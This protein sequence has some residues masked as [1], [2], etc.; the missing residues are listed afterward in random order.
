M[1]ITWQK[2]PILGTTATSIQADINSALTKCSAFQVPTDSAVIPN[3]DTEALPI[4]VC[5]RLVPY[6]GA[7]GM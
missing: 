3:Q 5:A 6:I 1:A 4:V 2:W 7:L